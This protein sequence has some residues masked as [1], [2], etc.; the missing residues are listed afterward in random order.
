MNRQCTSRLVLPVTALAAWSLTGCG[1]IG[2]P[3][4]ADAES[5]AREVAAP[6]RT[7][8]LPAGTPLRVRSL[9]ALSTRGNRTG[10]VFTAVLAEPLAAGGETIA[11]SGAE[12]RGL[13]AHSDPGGRVRGVASLS[14]RITSLDTVAG[15]VDVVTNTVSRRARRT[16]R[17]DAIKIGAGSGFGAAV[18]AIAGGGTGAAIGALAG[19]G[20]GAGLVLGT[21]GA[22]AVLP[23]ETL[24]TFKLAAPAEVT[25]ANPGRPR[26]PA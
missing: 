6:P 2:A 3:A 8:S 17:Q 23:S 16:R 7:I 22:P 26:R 14:V 5:R 13:V 10:D 20:A 24:L 15:P 11:P 18:G 25:L 9:T 4:A 21:R 19:G 1:P 12:V